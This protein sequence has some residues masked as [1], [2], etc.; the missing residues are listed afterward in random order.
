MIISGYFHHSLCFHHF[1][2]RFLG[3]CFSRFSVAVIVVSGYCCCCCCLIRYFVVVVDVVCAAVLWPL[4]RRPPDCFLHR[5]HRPRDRGTP[6][7]WRL[8]ASSSVTPPNST[9]EF[10]R[11]GNPLTGQCLIRCL[12]QRTIQPSRGPLEH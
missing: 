7:G 4:A 10:C 11:Q 8:S 3:N 9:W 12:N 5:L 2:E 6:P 1:L